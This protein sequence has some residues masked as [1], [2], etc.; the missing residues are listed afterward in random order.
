[1]KTAIIPSQYDIPAGLPGRKDRPMIVG[2]VSD[3]HCNVEG[4]RAAVAAM[5]RR[6]TTV[7][8]IGRLATATSTTTT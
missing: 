5:G 3:I 1:M 8:T 6:A 2:V 7:T 4:L